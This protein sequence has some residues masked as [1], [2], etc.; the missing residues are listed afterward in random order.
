MWK[1]HGDNGWH[2]FWPRFGLFRP[3]PGDAACIANGRGGACW[4]AFAAPPDAAPAR[5]ALA[6]GSAA[7]AAMG[8]RQQVTRYRPRPPLL[9]AR[10]RSILGLRPSWTRGDL[11]VRP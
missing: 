7:N 8:R 3:P 1:G 9:V 6:R 4:S 5:P 11:F 10:D 2:G